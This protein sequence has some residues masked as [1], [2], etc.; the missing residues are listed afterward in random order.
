VT[1]LLDNVPGSLRDA[2]ANTPSGGTVDFPS[3]LSGTIVLSG[4]PLS[5]N[6]DLT[7]T[8]PGANVITIDAQNVGNALILAYNPITPNQV[9]ISG[10]TFMGI[11]GLAFTSCSI[12]NLGAVLTMH[13]CTVSGDRAVHGDGIDNL[14][15][16]LLTSCTVSDFLGRGIVNDE[17]GHTATIIG[18]TISG[19]SGGGIGNY[20]STLTLTG[21]TVSGNG[22]SGT[23]VGGGIWNEGEH[24]VGTVT[25]TNS[26]LS[27]NSAGTGGGI[28][29]SWATVIVRD[30][31]ISG[32]SAAV[33]GGG[34]YNYGNSGITYE[35]V[36]ILNTIVAANSAPT[37]PDV[38]NTGVV[39]IA[40]GQWS[41]RGHNL[42]GD[43]SGISGWK[44]TDLVGTDGQPLDPK[45]GPLQVNGG[46]TTTLAPL[47]GSPALAAG[48]PTGAPLWDQRGPGYARVV[49]GHMDMGAVETQAS[50]AVVTGTPAQDSIVFTLG[51]NASDLT[52]SVNGVVSGLSDAARVEID[53]K[54]GG[55]TITIMDTAPAAHFLVAP[56]AMLLNGV[57]FFSGDTNLTWALIG[58]AGGD[59]FVL[60]PDAA[61]TVIGHNGSNVLVGP[62]TPSAWTITG[63]GRGTVGTVTFQGFA[64]LVGGN[65]AN[66]FHIEAGGV[67]G[68]MI[69]GGPGGDTGN[70]LMGPDT[71]GTQWYITAT[72]AGTVGPNHFTHVGNLVGGAS[73]DVF[74]LSDGVGVSGR[75]DGGGGGNTLNY[76]AYTTGV[77]VNMTTGVA[78]NVAGG[79]AN[80]QSA[81]GGSGSDLL[82]GNDQDNVLIGGNGGNDTLEGGGG[83]D[84]L[85]GGDGNDLLIGGP[86]R[87]VL[88]GGTGHDTLIAGNGDD[89][90]IAGAT[91]WVTQ[92]D[93]AALVAIRNE[94]IRLD[95]SFAQRISHL[96]GETSGGLNGSYV[97]TATTVTE[98]GAA[99]TVVQGSGHNWIWANQT[100]A[101]ITSLDPSGIVSC[102]LG[103]GNDIVGSNNGTLQGGATFAPGL[104]GQ[105]FSFNGGG[106]YV[107]VPY[108]SS[109]ALNTFTVQAW[110]NINGTPP[111]PAGGY[112]ILG[113]RVWGGNDRTFDVKI[114]TNQIDGDVGDGTNF[115][116]TS[117]DFPA[118]LKPGTW[119]LI[120]YV[121]DNGGKVFSLYLD[122]TLQRTISFSGTPLF[123]AASQTLEIGN[124]YDGEYFNGLIDEVV[125]YNRALSAADIQ[126]MYNANSPGQR[127]T[128][129]GTRVSVDGAVATAIAAPPLTLDP[130]ANALAS[131]AVTVG[132]ADSE[133][134]EHHTSTVA[135]KSTD[136]AN[137][138]PLGVVLRSFSAKSCKQKT[139]AVDRLFAWSAGVNEI[140]T[141]GADGGQRPQGQ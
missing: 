130:T 99:D 55:D 97:L 140:E 7:V 110:V 103:N 112:G 86:N 2:I 57:I 18:S 138:G 13:N 98:S 34:I 80:I 20:D 83:H 132:A 121:I 100:Q 84:I 129:D 52:V 32:N 79:I 74:R 50:T 10:L 15:T 77:L 90:L 71:P 68:N 40:V 123:M 134:A 141:N 30:S 122:G 87:S 54:G 36:F 124:S 14:G 49:N 131:A 38:E 125:L 82:I 5:I 69:D 128:I 47:V 62:D 24:P 28:Y 93:T 75:I 35:G 9:G 136:Q 91:P 114:E 63:K 118:T 135:F 107:S 126:G 65:A 19:N 96:R 127:P 12:L 41:S 67:I 45:L 88:I 133:V 101:T 58:Q 73:W 22:T 42:I 60:Q 21:S 11:S 1:T 17:S 78:T 23:G 43:G 59:T 39:P 31:T 72:D 89:L 48:D 16:L 70:T 106:A 92:A 76:A 44:T 105:A 26:T 113:T 104:V 108:S 102:W 6:E 8:G 137:T 53:G 27:G 33:E 64:T 139:T 37:S 51:A 95:E 25:V 85:V 111:G 61:A 120:T 115:I 94:W 66:T 81:T 119:H 29:N 109:L 56:N 116:N 4:S 46:P 3:G 117:V